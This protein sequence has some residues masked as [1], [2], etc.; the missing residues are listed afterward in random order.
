[1]ELFYNTDFLPTKIGVLS[2]YLLLFLLWIAL[3]GRIT[4]EIICFGIAISSAIYLF[5]IK[6]L[7]Y[8]PNNDFR[9]LRNFLRAIQYIF[10]LAVEIV[11]SSLMVMKF[12]FAK[13]FEIQPQIVF[14]KIPLK[15]DFLK[16]ILA[17][18]I[19]L[20]P[21]TITVDITDDVFCIHTMDYTLLEDFENSIFI[22]LLKEMEA[23]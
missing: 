7:E 6:Y 13:D 12:I 21:G 23:H 22:R 15:N 18:S 9:F 2:V 19:T 16:T 3:N 20:T 1:M 11:K 10:V 5:M 8:S 4:I 14:Y 17:N